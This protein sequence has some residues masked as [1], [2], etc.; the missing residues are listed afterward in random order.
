[1][2]RRGLFV[3][4]LLA[5]GSTWHA[6]EGT[7]PVIDVAQALPHLKAE[8]LAVD[9][10]HRAVSHRE[11]MELVDD[12]EML[13][14]EEDDDDDA[15]EPDLV[16][17]SAAEIR[18]HTVPTAGDTDQVVERA[19]PDSKEAEERG[20]PPAFFQLADEKV[21][22]RHVETT[23]TSEEPQEVAAA[24]G[25]EVEVAS[26][27]QEVLQS[28]NAQVE[29]TPVQVSAPV[30]EPRNA[31]ATSSS[32]PAPGL[33]QQLGL[34]SDAL[35]VE[36]RRLGKQVQTQVFAW[37][38]VEGGVDKEAAEST[39]DGG[40]VQASRMKVL[41]AALAPFVHFLGTLLTTL[42]RGLVVLPILVVGVV[43]IIVP[44]GCIRF[45]QQQQEDKEK[46]AMLEKAKARCEFFETTLHSRWLHNHWRHPAE[47]SEGGRR[48]MR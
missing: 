48:A 3:G 19:A 11:E 47:R 37:Y 22:Q 5:A 27:H 33:Q 1:M 2:P 38:T 45:G 18:E 31:T 9:F 7:R 6:A 30:E 8:E 12:D 10:P 17:E 29:D 28:A 15:D 39:Q 46:D 23:A 43:L 35:F 34:W 13:D 42:H 24:D 25:G 4:I 32:G 20:I 16:P 14:S 21:V 40:E 44:G 26:V 36:V 41:A